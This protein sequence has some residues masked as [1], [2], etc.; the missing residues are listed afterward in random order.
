MATGDAAINVDA[1]VLVC[2]AEVLANHALATGPAREYGFACLDEFHYYGEWKGT[3][4]MSLRGGNAVIIE[5][6]Y[7]PGLAHVACPR[8]GEPVPASYWPVDPSRPA[9]SAS[10][11]LRR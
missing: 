11:R 1:P 2:T 9:L 3:A 10:R 6:F 5:R 4:E 7:T 8:C